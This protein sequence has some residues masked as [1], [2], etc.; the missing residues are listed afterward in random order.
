LANW[1]RMQRTFLFFMSFLRSQGI[2]I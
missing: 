2:S 1:M